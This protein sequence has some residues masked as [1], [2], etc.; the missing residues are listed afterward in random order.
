MFGPFRNPL[1]HIRSKL[2]IRYFPICLSLLISTSQALNLVWHTIFPHQPLVDLVT[3]T[4]ESAYYFQI[5]SN[6]KF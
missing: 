1:M 5:S 4:H 2:V 6:Q 3:H